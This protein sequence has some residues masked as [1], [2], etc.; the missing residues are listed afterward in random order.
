M[1]RFEIT[2]AWCFTMGKAHGWGKYQN[3][4]SDLT[5]V[6]SK[7]PSVLKMPS[8]TGFTL[9]KNYHTTKKVGE[10]VHV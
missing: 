7:G 5:I 6:L 9:N 10:I 1:F 2:L 8:P 4:G 3:V